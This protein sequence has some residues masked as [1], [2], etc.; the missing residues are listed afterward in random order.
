MAGT[1]TFPVDDTLKAIVAHARSSATLRPTFAELYDPTLRLDGKEPGDDASPTQA[2]VDPARIPRGLW[3][4]MD[5]GVYL[6]SP[7]EPMLA[8]PDGKGSV[9]S[10]AQ[11]CNPAD[12]GWWDAKRQIV[13]GDDGVDKL[14]LEFFEDAIAD[15]AKAVMVQVSMTQLRLMR[16]MR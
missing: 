16:W 8:K 10:Y 12:E 5:Q 3:L 2:D 15:G 11:E 14:D 7:G 6:M 9:V 4:V 1:L 13:G